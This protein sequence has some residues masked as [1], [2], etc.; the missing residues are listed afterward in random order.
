MEKPEEKPRFSCEQC[1]KQC[2][3]HHSL[4]FDCAERGYHE[5][6]PALDDAGQWGWP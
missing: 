2:S 4:C 5:D 1:G 3:P 6:T